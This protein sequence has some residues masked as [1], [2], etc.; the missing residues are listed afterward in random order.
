MGLDGLPI[1]TATKTTIGPSQPQHGTQLSAPLELFLD[2]LRSVFNVGTIFR[3]ADGAK[4]DHIHLCGITPTPENP[5]LHKTA[6]G[7]EEV[8]PWSYSANGLQKA[9][10]LQKLGK[11]LWCLEMAKDSRSLYTLASPDQGWSSVQANQNG[12]SPSIV[13]I[14][15]NEIAGV[16]PEIQALADERI[17]LPM[18]GIKGSLNVAVALS[19]AL[20][21]IRYSMHGL[22]VRR[23]SE[24]Y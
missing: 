7:A 12:Q 20:Y 3:T 23:S 13:L 9:Q 4:V 21:H 1:G 22:I 24:R 15:G 19:I 18:L 14:V 2:N 16:D 10:E 5:R 8:V 17:H 6:L 11:Q